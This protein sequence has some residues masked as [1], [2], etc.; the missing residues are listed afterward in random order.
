MVPGS[1]GTP[2]FISNDADSTTFISND[3]DSTTFISNDADSMVGFFLMA[4]LK[5]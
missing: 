1:R 5:L 4:L 2:T 3:A